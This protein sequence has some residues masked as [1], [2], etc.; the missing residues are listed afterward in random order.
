MTLFALLVTTL[1]S[2]DPDS[3][4]ACCDARGVAPGRCPDTLTVVGAG[5]QV[6]GVL[7]SG[8]WIASCRDGAR[9]DATGR[10]ISA[11]PPTTDQI[12]STVAPEALSCFEQHC[13]WSPAVCLATGEDGR[14]RAVRCADG[15]LPVASDWHHAASAPVATLP[16]LSATSPVVGV[17][18]T[19]P[20]P[21]PPAPPTGPASVSRPTAVAP[22]PAVVHAPV[23]PRAPAAVAPVAVLA[24]AKPDLSHFDLPA[25]PPEPCI[26]NPNL[27]T[28][29]LDQT[30]AGDDLLMA[31][32]IE[33]AAEK[34]RAAVLILAC[35]PF[36]WSGLGETLAR[37]GEDQAAIKAYRIAT[38]LMPRHHFA[39]ARLANLAEASGDPSAA[40]AAW[41]Q[42]LDA[43]PGF[44][45]A[46]DA[47]T[48][49]GG[50]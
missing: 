48:R 37:A 7:T 44:T 30:Y 11:S 47:L 20:R 2:A 21:L 27:R 32:D 29:S 28:G 5:S 25:T 23:A 15:G 13:A 34:Y 50:L 3:L 9:F 33:G 22:A 10:R 36:A 35:N 38:R 24:A 14:S 18:P 16:Q 42:A 41:T 19:A 40:R 43:N 17:A 39:W 1:A 12:L 26:P 6:S 46:A 49:L 4:Q 31:G 45:P 8:V